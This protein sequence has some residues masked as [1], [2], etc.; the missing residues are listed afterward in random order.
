M[1]SHHQPFSLVPMSATAR[2]AEMPPS[3][4][5]S[6]PSGLPDHAPGDP[7]AVEPAAEVQGKRLLELQDAFTHGGRARLARQACGMHVRRAARD[8]GLQ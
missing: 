1:T 5:T 6:G 8:A 3:A 7:H 4:A 2:P